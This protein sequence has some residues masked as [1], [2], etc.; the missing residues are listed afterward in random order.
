MSRTNKDKKVNIRYGEDV[1]AFQEP[2]QKK[3]KK[4][5][6]PIFPMATPSWFTRLE[7]NRPQRREEHIWEREVLIADDLEEIDAPTIGKRPLKYY[8]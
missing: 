8:Y 3:Q 7:M 1:Y 4:N 2:D 5:F 6:N